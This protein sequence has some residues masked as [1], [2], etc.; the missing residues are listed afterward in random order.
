M[1]KNSV[2]IGLTSERKNALAIAEAGFAAISTRAA[3]H[4]SVSIVGDAL[5]VGRA[6]VGLHSIS[7]LLIVAVGKCAADA[8]AALEEVLGDR[9]ADGVVLDVRATVGLRRLR[10]YVG[11]H[12]M[13]TSANVAGTREILTLLT[14]LKKDDFVIFVISGGGST[15]LSA[16][17]SGDVN[18]EA[19]LLAGLFRAGAD[20]HEVNTVRKHLSLARG[21]W[22]AAKTNP[23]RSVSLIF[24]DMPGDDI[25]FIASGPTVKDETTVADAERVM[26]KYDLM[27]D[28]GIP[29]FS[30]TET[31]KDDLLFARAMH[32]IIVSNSIA[33]E[34]MAARAREFGYA[35]VIRDTA[36]HGEARMLAEKF[37]E[38]LHLA[39]PKTALLW[40]GESTV[41]AKGGGRG[42]RNL[43]MALAGLHHVRAGETF[44]PFASDGRDNG[45]WAGAFCDILT[46]D[47]AV[48]RGLSVE[49][50]LSHNDSYAFFEQAGH[51]VVTGPTGANVS[52]LII[53]LKQ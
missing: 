37:L 30:F 45:E 48:R 35:T 26:A 31:P 1:I 11:T 24:S 15:L 16:P 49:T 22:L 19:A 42:G 13:P 8:G 53:A 21:G 18:I 38:E 39:K 33:L 23:A 41:T 47:T 17:E 6:R 12:P 46:T 34:A 14:G 29:E 51:M 5:T 44:L 43:E 25:Q 20:I 2:E 7:R 4:R 52:D 40:G 32:D 50:F 9:I 36:F 3:I 27:K 10:E 28:T